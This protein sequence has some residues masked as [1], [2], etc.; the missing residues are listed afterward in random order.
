MTRTRTRPLVLL[1]VALG[2]AAG[3]AACGP[4]DTIRPDQGDST[5]AWKAKQRV[6]PAPAEG[7]PA[8]LDSE[9]AAAIHATYKDSLGGGGGKSSNDSGSRV[10]ILS[11]DGGGSRGKGGS[12]KK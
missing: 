3:L 1:A 11:D 7:Q 10:M 2:A 9:E 6:N 4:R 8:G 12:Y 5:R